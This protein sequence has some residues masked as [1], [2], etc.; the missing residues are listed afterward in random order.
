MTV[1]PLSALTV[2]SAC[3][4]SIRGARSTWPLVGNRNRNAFGFRAD[5]RFVGRDLHHDQAVRADPRH[6]LQ[7]QT[8]RLVRDRVRLPPNG[9]MFVAMMRRHVLAD[10]H[11]ARLTIQCHELRPAEHFQPPLFLQR[12]QQHAHRVA[13]CR[14]H[15]AAEAERRVEPVDREVRQALRGDVAGAWPAQLVL[16]LLPSGRLDC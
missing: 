16:R 13:R 11:V 8:D 2:V 12:P 4:T 15:E 1:W 7:N 14:E 9:S 6:D 3:V 5:F 10:L